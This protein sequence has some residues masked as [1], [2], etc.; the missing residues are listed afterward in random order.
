MPLSR[1]LHYRADISW[2]EGNR[3]VK[4]VGHGHNPLQYGPLLPH[5][6][7]EILKTGRLSDREQSFEASARVGGSKQTGEVVLP[8]EG[9]LCIRS[10][11]RFIQT[12]HSW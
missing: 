8:K 7:V 2:V 12:C 11:T 3:D 10:Y 4:G 6:L 1:D 9:L 5:R